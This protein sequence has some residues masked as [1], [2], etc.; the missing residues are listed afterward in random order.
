MAHTIIVFTCTAGTLLCYT[1]WYNLL[2]NGNSDIQKFNRETLDGCSEII[3]LE[4]VL[5]YSFLGTV[6]IIFNMVC[7]HSHNS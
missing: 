7:I 6:V 2:M 3:V 4:L 1:A 5:I